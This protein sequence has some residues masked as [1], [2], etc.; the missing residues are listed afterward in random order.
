MKSDQMKFRGV[1]VLTALLLGCDPGVVGMAGAPEQG[2]AEQ[3][4]PEVCDNQLDDNGDGEVDEDCFCAAETEQTCYAGPADTLGV[5]ICKA[6]IQA[7][8]KSDEFRVWDECKGAVL[9]TRDLCDDGI[10]NDCNGEMDDGPGCRNDWPSGGNTGGTD[11]SGKSDDPNDPNN[12]GD[13]NDPNNS[14]DPK[15][16]EPVE[17]PCADTCV[18]CCDKQDK[19]QKTISEEFCGVPGG[20]CDT[21]DL[22][23]LCDVAAGTCLPKP[24]KVYAVVMV[25]ANVKDGCE[26]FWSFIDECDPFAVVTLGSKTGKTGTDDGDDSPT[27][28]DTVFNATDEELTTN[29]MY[30][31]VRDDDSF[32][33]G[34]NDKIDSCSLTITQQH[35]TAGQLVTN[36]GKA[37]SLTINFVLVSS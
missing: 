25:S 12:S 29:T 3:D 19:C 31:E 34:S 33:Y 16:Q 20:K 17:P 9:P 22:E 8:G 26:G 27:W 28:N 36:C 18:G 1:M 35:L 37:H 10:D 15:D 13:P 23:E 11:G 14:G 6:G 5:G 7:C 32:A 2:K 21:C 4:L 30:V 24:P